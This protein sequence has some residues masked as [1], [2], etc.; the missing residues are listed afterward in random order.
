MELLLTTI[1]TWLSLNF[2]LP[3]TYELPVVEMA[4]TVRIAEMRYGASHS[5]DPSDVIAVYVDSRRTIFLPQ[6]WEGRTPTEVSILVHE[7][8]HHLQ[9]VGG[10]TYGCPAERE[11]LAYAAQDA[12]LGLFGKELQTEIEFDPLTF[13][14]LTHCLPY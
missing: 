14:L 10:L 2:G 3:A 7:L 12:W 1:A 5:V 4:P 6:S 8:V 13:K 11:Q 9:N